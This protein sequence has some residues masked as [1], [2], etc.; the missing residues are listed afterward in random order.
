MAN[1]D[2]P[3]SSQEIRDQATLEN[4]GEERPDQPPRST[5]LLTKSPETDFTTLKTLLANL[6]GAYAK[7]A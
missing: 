7:G 4:H 5:D 2:P 3:T 1:G 6:R